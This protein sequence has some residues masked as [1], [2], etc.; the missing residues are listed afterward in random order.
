MEPSISLITED[1]SGFE[2]HD[3]NTSPFLAAE[4][5]GFIMRLA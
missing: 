5:D 3:T 2:I 1:G 4:A